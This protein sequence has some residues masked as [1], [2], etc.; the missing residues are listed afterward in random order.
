MRN[1]KT[2]GC[3]QGIS[4][5][6]KSGLC[7]RCSSSLYYWLDKSVDEA[8]TRLEKLKLWSDRL[9]MFSQDRLLRNRRK[10]A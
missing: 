7:H 1:C 8:N 3:D 2:P 10:A 4:K 9:K 6:N 5:V